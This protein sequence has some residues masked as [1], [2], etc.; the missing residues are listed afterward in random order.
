MT[1]AQNKDMC[2][3]EKVKARINLWVETIEVIGR[4]WSHEIVKK[5]WRKISRIGKTECRKIK[6]TN[7]VKCKTGLR[8]I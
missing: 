7:T 4:T 2:C 6:T 1:Q 8:E 5:D 3:Q